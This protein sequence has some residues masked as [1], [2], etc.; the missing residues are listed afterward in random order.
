MSKWT[1]R[2][3]YR[4]SRVQRLATT[5][6]VS[7]TV[8][9]ISGVIAL[10]TLRTIWLPITCGVLF[11]LSGFIATLAGRKIRKIVAP[12]PISREERLEWI[13]G[14]GGVVSALGFLE[15]LLWVWTRYDPDYARMPVTSI[16]YPVVG[17]PSPEAIL[18]IGVV[19]VIMSTVAII[20]EQRLEKLR[21]DVNPHFQ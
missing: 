20:A 3:K 15:V 12:E 21:R 19:V 16:A 14:V 11:L 5:L 17:K 9:V 1:G 4:S 2:K 18:I 6:G 10:T 7:G 8:V 13:T